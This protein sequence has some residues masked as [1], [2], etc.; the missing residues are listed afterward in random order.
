MTT[1]IL[2]A[3]EKTGMPVFLGWDPQ[4]WWDHRPD[5]WNWFDPSLP[6][7]DPANRDNV[8][9]DGWPS[10]P[11]SEPLKISWLNWGRQLRMAPAQ[12]IH[13]PRV[14]AATHRALGA[15]SRAV[16]AWWAGASVSDHRL[17]A[18]I[19]LGCEAGIGWQTWYYPSGNKIYEAHPNTSK[20]DPT[21]GPNHT[22]P[23]DPPTWGLAQIGFSAAVA[24][25]LKRTGGLDNVDVQMLTRWYLGNLTRVA[26]GAGVPSSVLFTHY[27]GTLVTHPGGTPTMPYDAGA[28]PGL[29]LGISVYLTPVGSVP[30]FRAVAGRAEG[31]GAVE[32]GLGQFWSPRGVAVGSTEGWMAGLNATFGV[33]HCRLVSQLPCTPTVAAAAVGFVAGGRR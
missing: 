28:L 21:F 10:N 31:W 15:V 5:L 23:P 17:L 22:A 14:V 9:W 2:K 8:E 11:G 25:G 26:V 19:K 29:G 24:A 6:G 18:G 16:G 12:N 20:F 32:F 13:A 27:G 1:Q 3:A 7:Y 30:S 4:V 33:P